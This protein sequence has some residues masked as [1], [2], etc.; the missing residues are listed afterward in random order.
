MK[1][2]RLIC[3]YAAI[4]PAHR[5]SVFLKQSILFSRKMPNFIKFLLHFSAIVVC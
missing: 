4:A 1:K 2:H 5:S 3:L